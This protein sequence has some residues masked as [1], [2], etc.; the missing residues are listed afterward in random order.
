VTTVAPGTATISATLNGVK[1]TSKLTV[2]QPAVVSIALTPVNGVVRKGSGLQYKAVGTYTDGSTQDI[3]FKVAWTSTDTNVATV[4]SGLAQ[5]ISAGSTTI[6]ATLGGVTTTVELTVT[7]VVS[8]A[9]TPD[10]LTLPKGLWQLYRATG[11]YT[12]GTTQDLSAYCTWVST[13]TN[14]AVLSVTSVHAVGEG[15]T[16]IKATFDGITGSTP[17][18][19]TAAQVT[20]ITLGPTYTAIP[21]GATQQF[22]ATGAYTDGTFKDV[23]PLAVWDSS[24]KTIATISNDPGTQGIATGLTQ[25]TTKLSATIGSVTATLD[26]DVID[27]ILKALEISP[28]NA[29]IPIGTKQQFTAKGIFTDG[30]VVDDFNVIWSSSAEDVAKISN[31]FDRGMLTTVAQGPTTITATQYGVYA[32]TTLTVGPPGITSITIAPTSASVTKGTTKGFTATGKLTDGSTKNVTNQVSWNSS[33]P[34]VA[35][36]SNDV[37]TEGVATGVSI[38][39]TTIS[40]SAGAATAST[41]L[42]VIAPM[43][44][45]IAVTPATATLAIGYTQPYK[46]IG[47]YTDNSTEDL[48]TQVAWDS[49]VPA[50]ATVSN[51]AGTEGVATAVNGT[52]T[53]Q[54]YALKNGIYS[55][56]ADL[57]VIP[58][59]LTSIS[60]APDTSSMAVGT[61]Q[62]FSATGHYSDGSTQIL[63][64]LATWDSSDKSV[65]TISNAAGMQG[66]ATALAT[67]PTILSASYGGVTGTTSLTVTSA[68]VT[69]ITVTPASA[70]INFGANQQYTAMG[71]FDDGSMQDLTLT[72]SW[73][74]SQTSFATI[75]DTDPTKGLATGVTAGTT[76]ISATWNAVT[77]STGLTVVGAP[78]VSIK[79]TPNPVSVSRFQ[80]VQFTAVGTYADNS[81]KTITTL[82]IWSSTN[83]LSAN[84]SNAPGT[85]GLAT[86]TAPGF[87]TIQAKLDGITGSATLNVTF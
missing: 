65:A 43:L 25:G 75:S 32:S 4:A 45:S 86:T 51:A 68:A 14:V 80:Q 21:K 20:S 33:E 77:G 38:G 19:V 81:T 62:R 18:T 31:G 87:A 74:S 6:Q 53:T 69:S 54:I 37:G 82:V 49:T 59:Y 24:V 23:T 5:G 52:G 15:S 9:V 17:L 35:S 71:S 1:G 34:G 79:V 44:A 47:T 72:V 8:I 63:T 42:T 55:N 26:V 84:V 48:T 28:A 40:A 60:I 58:A 11:T 57:T 2:S 3:T 70:S 64:T 85:Q 39:S 10:E 61:R 67:G 22:K 73:S 83:P 41:T 12:D 16:I 27:P 30:S 46:A 76:T 13:D 50:Y 78:L 66:V 29:T 36:I 7:Q 56:F